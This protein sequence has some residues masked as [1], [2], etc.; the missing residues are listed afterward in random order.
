[1]GAAAAR[2]A[3]SLPF[4]GLLAGEGLGGTDDRVSPPTPARRPSR[5]AN[6]ACAR[7]PHHPPSKCLDAVLGAG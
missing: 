6:E 1:M 7:Q 5:H 4:S 3:V 2:R